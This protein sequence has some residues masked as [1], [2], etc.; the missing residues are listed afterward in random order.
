[1][2]KIQVSP[3][4]TWFYIAN[5]RPDNVENGVVSVEFTTNRDLPAPRC[6]PEGFHRYSRP[7]GE[8]LE[9]LGLPSPTKTRSTQAAGIETLSDVRYFGDVMNFPQKGHC[10]KTRQ[11]R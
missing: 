10:P 7:F 2:R 8:R 9:N 3:G 1:M 5:T 6:S 4:L 11:E